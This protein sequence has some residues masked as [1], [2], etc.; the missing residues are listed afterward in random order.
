MN[1]QASFDFT[2]PPTPPAGEVDALVSYLY[3][4]GAQWTTAK[5]ILADLGINDR[6]LRVLKQASNNRIV[7]GPGCPG[8]RHFQHTTCEQLNEV[9]ARSFS[10]IR[11]MSREYVSLK[12]FAHSRIP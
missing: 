8:Y 5:Q 9:L 1:S 4:R 2:A 3:Q 7:S 12:R 10:Q 6:K 11:A